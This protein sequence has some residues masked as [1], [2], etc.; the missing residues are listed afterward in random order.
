MATLGGFIAYSMS[1]N[2]TGLWDGEYHD[3]DQAPPIPVFRG[4]DNEDC[5]NKIS[6]L[7]DWATGSFDSARVSDAKL[8]A[9]Y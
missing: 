2:E 4:D 3:Y 9:S 1:M 7:F 6:D 5:R 8:N